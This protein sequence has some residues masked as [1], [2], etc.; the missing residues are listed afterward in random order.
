MSLAK[1]SVMEANNIM[2]DSSILISQL[3][4]SPSHRRRHNKAF[5]LIELLVVIAIIAIL[6]AMLLPALAK[7]KFRAKVINCTSNYKQWGIMANVY[8]NDDSQS[9]LP[10]FDAIGAGSDAW[11]V[12]T[13]MCPTL[14][15]Y[16]MTVPMWFCPVRPNEFSDGTVNSADGYF[17][18]QTHRHILNTTDLQE[19]LIRAFGG[20]WALINH[21]WWV[22]RSNNGQA[23]GLYPVPNGN[24]TPDGLND[25]PWPVKT[26]DV[27]VSVQPMISDYCPVQNQSSY[28][29]TAIT[30][31]CHFYDGS[32][33][34][35][36]LGFADG[37]VELHNKNNIQYR[38]DGAFATYY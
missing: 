9:R 15:Q 20:K 32:L 30:S 34:S 28:P 2:A 38:Y 24:N 7:S 17:Y 27:T 23:S 36:N 8:A 35:I 37:H 25:K 13:N 11:D 16:G 1:H 12:G 3:Q 31:G 10:R 19:Y 26:S 6:A 4:A 18:S 33:S 21:D 22:P 29:I 5:T 14:S